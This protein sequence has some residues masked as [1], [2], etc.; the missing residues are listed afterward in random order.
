MGHKVHPIIYRTQVTSTW[1]SRWFSKNNYAE[2][3]EQ[4]IRIREYLGKKFKDA[5]IDA[6]SVERGP[7]NMTITIQAAK[8]GFI[9]GRSGQGLELVRKH[10]ERNILSFTIK[11]KLNVQELRNPALSAPVVAQSIA[12]EIERRIPFRR[13]MKQAIEKTMKGGARG[14]KVAIAGRLNGAEIARTE[15]LSAGK[16]PLITLRSDI[17]YAGVRAHTVYGAIGI[18][19]WIYR[20]E[21]FIRK[22]RFDQSTEKDE[23]TK[24]RRDKRSRPRQNDIKDS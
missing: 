21:I 2:F 9:I 4:D 16:I 20:G 22:N 7:K 3:A 18:K 15:K 10:I 6:I 8:P 1:H 12:T 23:N 13:V 24:N 17:D 19:V 11:V 5:H 14:V